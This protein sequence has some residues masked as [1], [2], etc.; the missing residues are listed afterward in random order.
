METDNK[1][2]VNFAMARN[3]VDFTHA[4][5]GILAQKAIDAMQGM[6]SGVASELFKNGYTPKSGDEK[7]FVDKHHIDVIDYP[8]E[9]KDGL[10]F[11]DDSSPHKTAKENNPASYNRGEDASVSS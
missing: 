9:N 2:L 11:R 1:H 5:N 8:V 7:V 6:R 3:A 10:P 4:I